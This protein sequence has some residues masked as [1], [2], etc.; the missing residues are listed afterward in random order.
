MSIKDK[1]C[2][3]KIGNAVAPTPATP[4]EDTTDYGTIS[5]AP[6]NACLINGSNRVTV[7]ATV[8]NAKD[9]TI[10]W[11]GDAC[12]AI[13]SSGNTATVSGRG[14]GEHPQLTAR[15]HNGASA[16]VT[17]NFENN[18]SVTVVDGGTGSPDSDGKYFGVRKITTNIPAVFSSSNG[19]ILY[20]DSS[21]KTSVSTLAGMD[22]VVTVTTSCGQSKTIRWRAEIN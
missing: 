13:S 3:I 4:K 9:S 14:C 7:T 21:P 8:N 10:D 6:N 15:L 20:G 11:L 12:L 19:A 2:I 18:L 16:T 22:G 1:Y 17:F 5:L